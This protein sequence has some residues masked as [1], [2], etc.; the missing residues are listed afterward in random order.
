MGS[1]FNTGYRSAI[2]GD[3]GGLPAGVADQARESPGLA[4]E[5]A[6]RVAGARGQRPGRGRPRR[7][8]QR[9]APLDG[10]RCR[11][12]R[13]V[14]PSSSGS[15]VPTARKRPSRTS[16]T[17]TKPTSSPPWPDPPPRPK[18][19]R[20]AATSAA[21]ARQ[22]RVWG[23]AG[24]VSGRFAAIE[25]P[26]LA[27]HARPTST[28]RCR[29]VR[30]SD[31]RR[32]AWLRRRPARP[33][34]WASTPPTTWPGGSAPRRRCGPSTPST[35]AGSSRSRPRPSRTRRRPTSAS[36]RRDPSSTC[37]PTSCARVAPRLRAPRRSGRLP[38]DGRARAVG[39]R[40][41]TRTCSPRRRG[42]RCVFGGQRD[43]GRP[44]HLAA[45]PA[46]ART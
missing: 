29:P 15:A 17:P 10:R 44:A 5:V 36:R 33:P 25:G 24:W 12:P 7:L 27:P 28:R 30:R 45:G 16:S 18:L 11:P 23:R 19:T 21:R 3:L 1:M 34:G 41:S 4:L 20:W 6:H 46:R 8:H 26:L 2:D 42:R 38:A 22:F 43:R 9:H 40:R 39:R 31:G 35:A 13:G 14:P 32:R 37:R